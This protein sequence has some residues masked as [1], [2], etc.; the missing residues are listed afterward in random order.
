MEQMRGQHRLARVVC[1]LRP[2]RL[3]SRVRVSVLSNVRAGSAL[4]REALQ[5]TL[6]RHG[7]QVIRILERG[8]PL[9]KLLDGD[10]ELVVAA[11]GDGTVAAVARHLAGSRI[12]MAVLPLG[13]AN[14]LARSLGVWAPID[15]VIAGWAQARRLPI[16]LGIAEGPWGTR[17]FLEGVGAGLVSAGIRA[18]DVRPQDASPGSRVTHALHAYRHALSRLRARRF[19]IRLDGVERVDGE[20]LLVE[21]LNIRSVGSNLTLAPGADPSDGALDLVIA[22]PGHR[23]LV[24]EY[25][26]A[27]IQGNDDGLA[28]P[29]RRVRQVELHAPTQVHV[30]DTLLGSP[31]GG[32]VALH[33]DPAS[34]EILV[35]AGL[36]PAAG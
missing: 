10:V 18:A 27:R 1:F 28:L 33:V 8:A 20:F 5:P 7:H 21:A 19:V 11:G 32:H 29:S 16:D 34:V 3:R 25:L 35:H 14:N 31:R 2:T 22:E 6:E 12:P 24:K 13:T 23:R 15:T 36:T 9:T 4:P 17:Y 26:V 30:D